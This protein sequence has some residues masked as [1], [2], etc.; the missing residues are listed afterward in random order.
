M[1]V[2]FFASA[3]FSYNFGKNVVH[4]TA[5]NFPKEIEKRANTT[6]YLVMFHGER[7]P[8]CQMAYPEFAE[9]AND[10]DGMLKF[11]HIDTSRDPALA[12][13]F[14]IYGIPT[15]IIFHPQGETTYMR[16]RSSRAFLNAAARY[17]PDVSKPVDASWAQASRSVILFSDKPSAPPLW[18]SLSCHYEGSG[19][20]VGFT[21]D[22]ELAK[23]FNVRTF[24]EI[25]L[26]DGEKKMVYSGRNK[27]NAIRETIDGFMDGT[28]EVTPTPTP[29]PLPKL[30][31]ELDDAEEMEKACTGKGVFCVFAGADEATKEF[32]EVA[33]KYRHDHFRFYVCGPECP[34]EYARKGI[35]VRHHKRENMAIKVE[36]LDALGSTLD[37][38]VDG[39]AKFEP[40]SKLTQTDEL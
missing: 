32:E 13:R 24:P 21:N 38:V 8:A 30:V 4:L 1:L 10:A 11:G 19:I 31:Y 27:F 23:T 34:V 36:S 29:T 39:G 5:N 14:N 25:H 7:C 22:Q 17:I 3:A 20:S 35:W 40:I 37:R 26:I 16:D 12:S 28:I 18:R 6:V 9:A 33:K 15:F 2:L